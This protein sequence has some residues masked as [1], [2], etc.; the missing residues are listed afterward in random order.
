MSRRTQASEACASAKFRHARLFGQ[1]YD[2]V[3]SGGMGETPDPVAEAAEYQRFIL[4]Q[5]G[6]DD[7]A[8]VQ[9][10]TPEILRRLFDKAGDRLRFQ[11]AKGKWSVLQIA[12]HMLDGEL[13]SSARYRWI[14]AQDEPTLVGYDQDVWVERLKHQDADPEEL[15]GLFET[16]RTANLGLWTRSSEA[17]R[18]RVGMHEERGPESFELT[19]RLIG[20]HDRNHL[21][22]AS[23][24]L[25]AL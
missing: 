6:D 23:E 3:Q 13:V 20:G 10:E 8:V 14:L 15:L 17:E 16:L 24:T 1:V 2:A 11:P 5:L 12:G 21:N 22:Q 19:F 18:A 9:A 7:P 4:S 25:A